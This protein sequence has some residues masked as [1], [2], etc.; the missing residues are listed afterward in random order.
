MI[1]CRLLIAGLVL[2]AACS[3]DPEVRTYQLKGQIL[4][5]KPDTNEI[6]VKHEDI[7]GFMPAMTMT[8]MVKDA[9][10]LKDRAPGD[11]ITATLTV[12]STLGYLSA[13]IKTGSA[14]LPEGART[15]IPAAANVELLKN[16][17]RPPE[18]R[19]IDQ[20]EKPISLNDFRGVATAI[21]FIYTRCPLPQF[22]PLMDRRF[23]EAQ[24]L[25]VRDPELQGRV[26]L[27]TI[28]FDP[29]FDRS[30]VLRAHARTLGANPLLW[31]FATA[32]EAVVDRFAAAFGVNVIR[33]KDGTITHN[34]RTA[35]LDPD[36]R[37]TA[38]LDDAWTADDL[39]RELK[40]ALVR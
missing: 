30:A 35:V 28:S 16:G 21:T 5:V 33:E 26:R 12:E 32:D 40:A 10:L 37:V 8:Y 6:L 4:A 27:L 3:R 22:C 19:L 23:A 34:L 25:V 2:A 1:H 11:L 36:G 38:F 39:V 24:A 15:T 14:P 7:P 17:D 18:A 31:R 9:V 20:D 29:R 13:I